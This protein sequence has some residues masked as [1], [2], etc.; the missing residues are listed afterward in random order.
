MG[1]VSRVDMD[2]L[3][4]GRGRFDQVPCVPSNG[5]RVGPTR[6]DGAGHHEPR[7]AGGARRRE[8]RRRQRAGVRVVAPS[9]YGRV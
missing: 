1:T 4:N 2:R 9:A 3:M 6:Q 5:L 7:R 8:G